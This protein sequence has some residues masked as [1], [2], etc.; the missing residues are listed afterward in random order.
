M[1]TPERSMDAA[2]ST[3][4]AA[5]TGALGTA[6]GSGAADPASLHATSAGTIRVAIWPGAV[7]AVATA[8]AASWP[9]S[10]D[11]RDVR[12]HLEYGCAIASMSEVSGVS[13]GRW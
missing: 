10:A 7:R 2:C 5:G 11:D 8:W 1:R 12:S 4:S 9:T 6:C 3:A 13:S